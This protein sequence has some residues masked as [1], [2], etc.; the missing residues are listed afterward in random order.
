MRPRQGERGGRESETGEGKALSYPGEGCS[1][2]AL[3]E[4]L[5]KERVKAGAERG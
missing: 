5:E 2:V 3:L 4:Q 1:W